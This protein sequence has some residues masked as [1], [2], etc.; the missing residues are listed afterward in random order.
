MRNRKGTTAQGSA[1][2]DAESAYLVVQL[3]KHDFGLPDGEVA[4][5]GRIFQPKE[6]LHITILSRSAAETLKQRR[7]GQP[8]DLDRV[9]QLI[10][11]TDW[12]YRKRNEFYRVEEVPGIESIV[13]MVDA[14]SLSAFFRELSQIA[15]QELEP[16][17]AHVTLY[18]RGNPKGIGLSTRAIFEQRVK[19]AVQPGLILS[20]SP[21][22]SSA[23]N[24]D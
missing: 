7:E 6:E 17:P 14:P 12:S 22:E 15:G 13:Q 4:Y 16:P 10:E 5:R 24:Q 19:E 23:E 18:T 8:T 1:S 9:K 3:D 21:Y 2:F 20:R 11:D